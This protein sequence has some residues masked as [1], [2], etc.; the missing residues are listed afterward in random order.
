MAEADP[1]RRERRI[2]QMDR[3]TVYQA[4]KNDLLSDQRN[5]GYIRIYYEVVPD[6]AA[7]AVNQSIALLRE[8]RHAGYFAWSVRPDGAHNAE[9]PAP[10]GEEFYVVCL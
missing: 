9:G 4:L 10:D 8:G 1:A 5:S 7:I 2:R 6:A 3:G